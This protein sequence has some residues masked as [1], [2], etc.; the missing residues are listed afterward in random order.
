MTITSAPLRIRQAPHSVQSQ[1]GRTNISSS[2]DPT[3]W[4]FEGVSITSDNRAAIKATISFHS[5]PGQQLLNFF[6]NQMTELAKWRKGVPIKVYW[7]PGHRG[8]P[9]NEEADKLAKQAATQ[10]CKIK[11]L[12]PSILCSHLP[13]SKYACKTTYIK[14]LKSHIISL[15]HESLKYDKMHAI[16]P[17][18]PSANYRELTTGLLCCQSIILIQ[19]HTGHTQLNCHFHNI[20]VVPTPMCPAYN[21]KEETVWY[22]LLSCMAYTKHC[23]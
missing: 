10:Q 6:L 7:I 1:A 2:T 20:G 4:L 23:E 21:A 19:L 16:N 13:H 3:V 8:I 12:L 18:A 14:Q 11:P 22:F 9:G 17:K 5:I 15:F